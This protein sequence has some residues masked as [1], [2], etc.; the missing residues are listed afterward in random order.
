METFFTDEDLFDILEELKD[1]EI[2]ND[3]DDVEMEASNRRY[4][5]IIKKHKN[6]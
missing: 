5:E 1:E 2:E 3:E 4:E 6:D